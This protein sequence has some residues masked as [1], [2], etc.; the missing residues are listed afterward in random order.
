VGIA[1]HFPLDRAC[2]TIVKGRQIYEEPKLAG[3]HFLKKGGARKL[4]GTHF[5]KKGGARKLAG[6]H[7]LKKG[8]ARKL[9]GPP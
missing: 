3:T 6:T 4:A 9:A 7:F 1:S 5:L 8:G 2:T